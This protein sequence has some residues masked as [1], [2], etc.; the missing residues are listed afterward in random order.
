MEAMQIFFICMCLG[1]GGDERVVFELM[2]F[3]LTIGAHVHGDERF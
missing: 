3:V 1:R 2:H